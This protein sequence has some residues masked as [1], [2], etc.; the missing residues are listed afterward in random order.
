MSPRSGL[1]A[2]SS[3]AAVAILLAVAALGGTAAYYVYE[4]AHAAS[5]AYSGQYEASYT[6][7]YMDYNGGTNGLP[8][9]DTYSSYS[10]FAVTISESGTISGSFEATVEHTLAI[11]EVYPPS[12]WSCY[13]SFDLS[14]TVE[15]SGSVLSN[16]T[17]D[18]R[19]SAGSYVLSAADGSYPY[20]SDGVLTGCAAT[21]DEVSLSDAIQ[22]LSGWMNQTRLQIPLEAG[23][24][25]S[26][27]ALALCISGGSGG[28]SCSGGVGFSFDGEPSAFARSGTDASGR[29]SPPANVTSP[30]DDTVNLSTGSSVKL[31]PGTNLSWSSIGKF[32]QELGS[33]L[34]NMLGDDRGTTCLMNGVAVAAVRGA[35]FSIT[36]D[37]D[38]NVSVTAFDGLV[39]VIEQTSGAT[40][41]LS[42]TLGVAAQ[43][44]SVWDNGTETLPELDAGVSNATSSSPGTFA[45]MESEHWTSAGGPASAWPPGRAAPYDP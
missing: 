3:A 22:L 20:V 9:T 13:G 28:G 15:V 19:L 27:V 35:E 5:S 33:A 4:S 11:A 41:A 45:V 39:D 2:I 38:G 1:R 26:S 18:V 32:V 16:G 8:E 21:G 14:G 12:T 36:L 23:V 17:A 29:I 6:V 7:D 10:S 24:V 40:V 25:G 34:Y 43:Q 31:S 42:G 37:A 30:P 44:I